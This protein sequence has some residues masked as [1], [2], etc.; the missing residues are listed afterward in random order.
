MDLER[1][2]QN[3]RLRSGRTKKKQTIQERRSATTNTEAATKAPADPPPLAK[4]SVRDQYSQTDQEKTADQQVE[5]TKPSADDGQANAQTPQE[6]VEPDASQLNDT[7]QKNEMTSHSANPSD[8]SDGTDF[9]LRPPAPRA[10]MPTLETISELLFSSGHLDSILHDP[11]SISRFTAFLSR[12][13]PEYQ[14]LIVRYLETQ[15]AIRAV[16]YANAVAAGAEA[17]SKTD[18]K[19]V[20]EP[21]PMSA[22]RLDEGFQKASTAAFKALVGEALPQ[23]ITYN[24]VRLV[25]ECLINEVAGRQSAIMQSL[26]GGLS[27][28]FCITDPNQPD[29]PIIYAS[30]EFYRYTGY[31]SDDVIGNNCRFLQGPKTNR[32]SPRRIQEA[33]A[34]G[35]EICETLLNYRRDGRPFV[36]LLMIAPLHDNKG[37]L[38]YQIGAQV[39]VSGLVEKGR[40]LDTFARYLTTRNNDRGR[41]SI[42]GDERKQNA[43]N[44]LRELSEMFDLEESTVVQTHS[45]ANSS[46]R[47]PEA[48]VCL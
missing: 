20:Q 42:E 41:R 46:T 38:K 35:T 36:N 6:P 44:K 5:R 11:Q 24:L 33:T 31:A 26:V 21:V 45:R 3:L 9:D 17:I 10:R 48:L 12:Y 7:R 37:R 30:E 43:L 2:K 29:N 1:I 22:A 16:E 25:S 18:V 19:S 32:D 4:A 14:P 8:D 47:S 23:F 27:E 34:N 40:G 28:V 13:R 39:D 15:K